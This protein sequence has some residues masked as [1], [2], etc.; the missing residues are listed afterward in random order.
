MKFY[1]LS[2]KKRIVVLDKKVEL[3]VF[4]VGYSYPSG[5]SCGFNWYTEFILTKEEFEK[6]KNLLTE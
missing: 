5:V 2:E 4:R 1:E 6:L 3:Q